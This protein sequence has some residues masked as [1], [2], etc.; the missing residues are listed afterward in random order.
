[1]VMFSVIKAGALAMLGR[2]DEARAV[3]ARTLGRFP[4]ITIESYVNHPEWAD[5]ERKR[6]VEAM[7]MAGFPACAPAVKLASS[8]SLCGCQDA[9]PSVQRLQRASRRHSHPAG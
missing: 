8:R 7:K 4:D 9:R 3:V 1:M 2:G 5:H 6:L